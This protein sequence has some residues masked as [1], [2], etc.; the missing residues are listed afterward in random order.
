MFTELGYEASVK[1]RTETV[2]T[3]IASGTSAKQ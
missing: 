3:S 2:N 1:R